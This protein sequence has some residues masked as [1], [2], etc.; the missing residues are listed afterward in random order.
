MPLL[1]VKSAVFASLMALAPLA[2][3]QAPGKLDT[4]AAELAMELIGRPVYAS[5]GGV[6]GTVTDLAF[7]ESGRPRAMRMET[8]TRLGLGTRILQVPRGWFMTLRG[9]VVLDMPAHVV[10]FLPD[11]ADEDEAQR[12]D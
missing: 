7:D 3:A 2:S 4:E 9:A 6:V 11:A 8:A 12:H 5:D 1:S 10:E